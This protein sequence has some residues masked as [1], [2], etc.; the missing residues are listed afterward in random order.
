MKSSN[1]LKV[2]VKEILKLKQRLNGLLS[3]GLVKFVVNWFRKER[4]N[5]LG[6]KSVLVTLLE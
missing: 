1:L 3:T 5:N 6:H 2:N 4:K